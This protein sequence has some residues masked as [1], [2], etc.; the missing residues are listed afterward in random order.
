[1]FDLVEV[2]DCVDRNA[3][4]QDPTPEDNAISARETL[5]PGE[6]DNQVDLLDTLAAPDDSGYV[7]PGHQRCASHTLN[8]IAS[9]DIGPILAEDANYQRAVIQKAVKLW[10]AQSKSAGKKEIIYKFMHRQLVT[11]TATRWNS[12]Y[13]SLRFLQKL[14]DAPVT[15]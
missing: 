1:M 8:L 10:A 5:D 15:R 3:M 2:E 12:W 4:E 7:L 9:S 13:D 6:Q 14:H 11:P